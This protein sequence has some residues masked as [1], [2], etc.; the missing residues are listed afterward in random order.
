MDEMLSELG[1]KESEMTNLESTESRRSPM[2]GRRQFVVG[3][4]IG[5]AGLFSGSQADAAAIDTGQWATYASSGPDGATV[6]YPT[7]WTVDPGTDR[8]LSLDRELV[9]PHQSFSVRTSVVK[10]PIDT[11][12]D[13]GGLPDLTGYPSDAAILWFM[14]YDEIVEGP[15]FSGL[16][17]SGLGEST[18]GFSGFQFFVAR[19]SNSDRSFLLWLWLGRRAPDSTVAAMDACLR[20]ITVP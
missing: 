20:T 7:S 17:L 3:G 5:A 15:P 14:Y 12:A 4:V 6:R 1:V 9:Y 2:F 10:P 13:G 18:S 11:S 8:E 19:L 16:S